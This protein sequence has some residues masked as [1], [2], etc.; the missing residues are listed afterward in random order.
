MKQRKPKAKYSSVMLVDDSEIDNFINQKMVEGCNFAE[1]VYI[2][3]SSKSGLEFLRN[4]EQAGDGG[5]P[6]FPEI[7]FLDINMPMMD[8][9]QFIEEFD[10]L[11]TALLGKTKIVMLT[12]SINPADIEKAKHLSSVH[13]YINKP[14]SQK[15][16]DLL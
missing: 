16:L 8:G 5:T 12:T 6:L 11:N 7:I 10:K 4:L 14:L 13:K 3:T 2:H 1:R 15:S 9:F